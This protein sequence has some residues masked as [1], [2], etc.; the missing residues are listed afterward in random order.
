MQLVVR[1]NKNESESDRD[2]ETERKYL[3]F[4]DISIRT[5][6]SSIHLSTSCTADKKHENKQHEG[7]EK[8]GTRNKRKE[9]K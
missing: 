1:E 2:S 9:K 5:N 7:K 3:T 4:D 8:N 6:S